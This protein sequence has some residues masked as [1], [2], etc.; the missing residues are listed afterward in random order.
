[1]IGFTLPG[2][3]TWQPHR[4]GP[5]GVSFAWSGLPAGQAATPWRL[6]GRKATFGRTWAIGEL[7]AEHR[8]RGLRWRVCNLA[9]WSGSRPRSWS[10]RSA[11]GGPNSGSGRPSEVRNSTY[12]QAASLFGEVAA[13][14]KPIE[15]LMVA[16]STPEPAK[17]GIKRIL[18]LP[19]TWDCS[20]SGSSPGRT[21]RSSWSQRAALPCEKTLRTSSST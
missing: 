18:I 13:T 9:A 20:V 6:R 10:A 8:H 15:P 5:V 12:F 16:L 4:P 19:V 21:C 3:S 7:L 11:A 17:A 1:M 2:H 14:E